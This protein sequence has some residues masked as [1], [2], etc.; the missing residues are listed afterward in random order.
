MQKKVQIVSR[1]MVKISSS[2]S[3]IQHHEPHK[4]SF[5]DQLT[6]TTYIPII[7]FYPVKNLSPS[8]LTSKLK[9]ALLKTLNLYYPLSGRETGNLYID[10]FDQ[11]VPFLEAQVS[12]SF[13][14]FLKHHE[15]E[16]LNNLLPCKP[17]SK[18]TDKTNAPLIAVQINFFTC[19]SGIALGWCMSHKILDAAASSNFSTTW[20]SICRGD[21]HDVVEPDLEQASL[22][23]P[24]PATVP[25]NLISLME[26]LWFVKGD[27]VTSRFVFNAKAI[28][29]LRAKAK[30]EAEEEPSRIQTLSCFIWKCGMAASKSISGTPKTSILVETMNLRPKTNPPMNDSSIGNLFWWAVAMANPADTDSMKLNDLASM[31]SE[32]INL[33]KTDYTHSFQGEKGFEMMSDFCEQLR[34]VFTSE[35][36]DIFAFTSWS[37]SA[38]TRPNFGWGEPYWVGVMGKPGQ[39][40]RNLT[41]FVDAKDGKAIEAW[42]TLEKQKMAILLQDPEFL[43]F[44]SPNPRFSSI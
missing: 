33:Y 7:Y 17:F 29:A 30:G 40:F 5:F 14:D 28:G 37:K 21:L 12:C 31:V 42:I 35:D 23:F 27:Y 8:T 34:E 25:D 26:N 11:G 3:I 18:E 41:V 6:P 39:E 24:S 36:T 1:D 15:P 4:L 32:S 16:S 43:E 38:F 10:R 2:P 19:G 44:A 20:A 22:Y 9:I 13:S